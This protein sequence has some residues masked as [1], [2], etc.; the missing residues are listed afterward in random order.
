[1]LVSPGAVAGSVPAVRSLTT[2]DVFNHFAE[3][4]YTPASKTTNA[5]HVSYNHAL[6]LADRREGRYAVSCERSEGTDS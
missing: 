1:M 5:L 3:L 4:G 2:C 6:A